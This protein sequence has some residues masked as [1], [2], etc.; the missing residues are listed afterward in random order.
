[1]GGE[2]PETCWVTNKRQ[3]INLWNYCILLVDLFELYEDART[4][5]RQKKKYRHL[6]WSPI[7][8]SSSFTVFDQTVT[9]FLRVTNMCAMWSFRK[10]P[11]REWRH[12]RE[13]TLFSSKLHFIIDRA[14]PKSSHFQGL[15]QQCAA[16][17][18]G[19]VRRIEDDMQER[20]DLTT[21]THTHAHTHTH[22]KHC[23]KHL[24]MKVFY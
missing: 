10:V 3:V 14:E 2:A 13:I 24:H 1:M 23:N 20:Y 21:H 9:F 15:D 4:C 7:N 6:L 12:R 18:F 19:V 17:C 8:F 16:W 5:E 11:P 22:M